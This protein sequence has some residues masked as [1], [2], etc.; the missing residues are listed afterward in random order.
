M[1]L[2]K[3][4]RTVLIALALVLALP[5]F[6]ACNSFSDT[7]YAIVS[8]NNVSADGFIY[9]KYE[10]ST[11]RITGMESIPAVLKIPS[12]IDDMPVIEIGDSAFADST[13]LLYLELPESEIKLGKSFCSGCVALLA[14]KLSDSV[15]RIP[16]N[17][18]ENCRDLSVIEG[19]SRVTEIAAQA[20]AGCSSLAFFKISDITVS[21]GNEA[22]RGCSSLASVELPKTLTYL[23]DSAFWGCESLV[24]ATVNC[25][26]DIPTYCFLNCNALT[27][28]IIGDKVKAIGEE[29][30]RSCRSLYSI[31]AGKNLKTVGDYAF[32]ACDSLTEISFTDKS[33]VTVGEGNEALGFSN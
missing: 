17:A 1:K 3:I 18:F 6:A 5:L 26:A 9:D 15:T 25:S 30:F 16:E 14:V 33:S 10:N 27:E 32:H 22:F 4:H 13:T 21:I 23:G 24:T 12:E 8:E 2:K 20:F 7:V 19:A 31:S 29:A 28:V 11:V